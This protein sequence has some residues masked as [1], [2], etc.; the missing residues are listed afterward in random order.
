MRKG[1]VVG[2]ERHVLKLGRIETQHCKTDSKEDRQWVN[3][4]TELLKITHDRKDMFI[5]VLNRD[6]EKIYENDIY[7]NIER[8]EKNKVVFCD[9]SF[10][11]ERDNLDCLDEILDVQCMHFIGI[12]GA[13]AANG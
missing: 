1:Q 12:E 9:G 7:L 10:A 4:A 8:D 11:L 5:G 13:E 6:G 3:I 2:Y